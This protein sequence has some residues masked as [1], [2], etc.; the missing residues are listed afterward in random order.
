VWTTSVLDRRSSSRRDGLVEDGH[1]A[2]EHE[3]RGRVPRDRRGDV[4]EAL[5]MVD[6]VA[7]QQPDADAVLVGGDP[8][9]LTFSS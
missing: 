7:A 2:V 5:P 8:P 1:L 4:W 6:V 3:R 9:P